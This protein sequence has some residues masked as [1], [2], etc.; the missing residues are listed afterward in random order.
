MYCELPGTNRRSTSDGVVWLAENARSS[1][2]GRLLGQYDHGRASAR[3]NAGDRVEYLPVCQI[4]EN[5]NT[6]PK[7]SKVVWHT[8]Y[9]TTLHT[10]IKTDRYSCYTAVLSYPGTIP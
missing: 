4:L 3:L 8:K 6:K 10:K 1:E 5:Q 2:R 7:Q 9:H